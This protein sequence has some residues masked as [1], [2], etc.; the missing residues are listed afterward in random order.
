[1]SPVASKPEAVRAKRRYHG[2]TPLHCP[3]IWF[4]H[5]LPRSVSELRLRNKH[6]EV[7]TRD[8]DRCCDPRVHGRDEACG[9]PPTR[10]TSQDHILRR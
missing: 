4:K 7:R 6:V 5:L 9:P 2:R 1:M 10:Q 3:D 8:R